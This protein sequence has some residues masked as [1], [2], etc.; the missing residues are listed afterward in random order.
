MLGPRTMLS[1]LLIICNALCAIKPLLPRCIQLSHIVHSRFTRW[2]SILGQ[3][4]TAKDSPRHDWRDL[5]Y[6]SSVSLLGE[7][8]QVSSSM[9]RRFDPQWPIG[10]QGACWVWFRELIECP[11][12]WIYSLHIQLQEP[13]RMTKMFLQVLLL[14]DGCV[15]SE[16]LHL[17]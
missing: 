8:K 5:L 3:Y 2:H 6:L 4:I 17:Y 15:T 14:R 9:S 16:S 13:L 1:S 11:V 10:K 12:L 7:I